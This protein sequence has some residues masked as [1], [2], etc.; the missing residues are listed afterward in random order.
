[1]GL[2]NA[3]ISPDAN[4]AITVGVINWT[5]VPNGVTIQN[6]S[7]F[8]VSE[9]DESNRAVVTAKIRPAARNNKTGAYTKEKKEVIVSQPFLLPTGE[10][11]YETFRIIRESHPLVSGVDKAYLQK[12]VGQLVIGDAMSTFWNQGSAE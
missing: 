6:G 4:I 2:K 5:F 8:V 12:T 11:S 1:M 3:T 9:L 10:V 7:Q